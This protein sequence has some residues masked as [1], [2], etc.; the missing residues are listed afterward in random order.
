MKEFKDIRHEPDVT[1]SGTLVTSPAHEFDLEDWDTHRELEDFEFSDPKKVRKAKRKAEK[2]AY[3]LAKKG[4]LKPR[5]H[6]FGPDGQP[7]VAQQPV[8][9]HSAQSSPDQPQGFIHSASQPHQEG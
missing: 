1:E 4:I 8:D 3:K 2:E 9:I 5:F 6:E 7:I